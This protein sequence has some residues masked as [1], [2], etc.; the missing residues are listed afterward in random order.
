M[1]ITLF[2]DTTYQLHG[3]IHSVER[4]EVAL[5]DIQRPFVWQASRVRDLFDSMYRGFPVGYLLFWE[6]GAQV[7]AR[8]IGTSDKEAAP[9]LLVVDG[10][11]R[12][13]SLYAVMTGTPVVRADYSTAR[14]K[15]AFRPHDATFAVTDAA[16]EKDPEYMADVSA[17][18]SGSHRQA[19]RDF[20]TRLR[21]KRTL[22]EKET[23]RL[24][25]ALDR[26]KDLK[27][28]PF[29]AVELS[30]AVEEEQV[31][32]IFVRINS[33][34][35]KLSRADFIL[36]LMSVYWEKGRAEL[37]EFA[38]A[39]KTPAVSGPS[40]FNWF[41]KPQ[42]D[43]MLRVG[44]ALAFRRA[45]LKNV[46]Q[47]LRGKDMATGTVSETAR[48]EQF[49]KLA[50]AQ[51]RVLDLTHWHE[52]LQC[53]ELAGFRS[54]AMVSSD[55]A[56]LLTYAFWLIGR[57]DYGLSVLQLRAVI[58]RWFFMAHLTG[59]YTG[60]FESQFE[61]DMSRLSDAE[62]GEDFVALLDGIVDDTL[63]SDYWTI[64]LPN[65]LAT[66]AS[67]SPALSAYVAALNIL[68]ADA[69]MGPTK[70]RSR[71]DPAVTAKKG[72]ERHHLFPKAYLKSV[73]GVTDTKQINQ[74]ANMTLVDWPENIAVSSAAPATYWPTVT[75]QLSSDVLTKQVHDHALPDSWEHLD[76][77]EFLVARR[78]LMG[79]VV[80]E[81]FDRLKS[82]GTTMS[83]T[84]PTA[85]MCQDDVLDE[86][87]LADVH[88]TV[89]DLLDEGVL[90]VGDVLA[91]HDLDYDALATVL[92]EGRLDVDGLTYETADAAA[93][94]VAGPDMH[95]AI[96]WTFETV[97]GNK[98]LGTLR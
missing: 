78:S 74:I 44:I 29:K 60:S 40:P 31:A 65:A 22:D 25:E 89:A 92:E 48:D 8:Q 85:P 19:V 98:P 77:S 9:R 52:F 86:A 93:Q 97:D 23:D 35:V 69:L 64:T 17:L 57:V 88:V 58:A 34:G 54:A 4:G 27:D 51:T 75:A 67:K 46:Y 45:V 59:R 63:S 7:G 47:M 43:Q 3:L 15:I 83:P 21:S 14:I 79:A 33:E 56:L 91:P 10:Q 90:A 37:E 80:R 26:L 81:A 24:D 5:P 95:G 12:L 61:S 82:Q 72:I 94:A 96:F 36:T 62:T 20:L 70:V 55:N 11:Q 32:E 49:A 73:L 50:A 41:I 38:R 76:Y 68:D 66:S 53:I 30:S 71:L 42:P 1:A 39:A 13:T 2:R 6:T 28:Y 87:P 16:I 18:W 84:P